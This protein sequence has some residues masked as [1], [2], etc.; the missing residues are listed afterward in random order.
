[1][2]RTTR[3][4]RKFHARTVNKKVALRYQ[5]LI[6]A[7]LTAFERRLLIR[8]VVVVA[9]ARYLSNPIPAL[10]LL[11]SPRGR[12]LPSFDRPFSI[13]R[14]YIYKTVGANSAQRWDAKSGRYRFKNKLLRSPENLIFQVSPTDQIRVAS[15]RPY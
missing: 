9:R 14:V 1:M 15:R 13:S 11:A 4:L 7:Q 2:H 6:E 3:R 12:F 5:R 8:V 10:S